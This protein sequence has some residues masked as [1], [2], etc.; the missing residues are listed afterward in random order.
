MALG[1]KAVSLGCR[2]PSLQ[3]HTHLHCGAG[4]SYRVKLET[5]AGRT[6]C[7]SAYPR[8]SSPS[9]TRPLLCCTWRLEKRILKKGVFIPNNY[10]W[11]VFQTNVSSHMTKSGLCVPE[12]NNGHQ[13]GL[14]W[15]CHRWLWFRLTGW[16][17]LRLWTE[18]T[19][20]FCPFSLVLHKMSHSQ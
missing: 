9:T 11:F 18:R 14:R 5:L 2:P 15:V 7:T 16:Y 6:G 10:P 13:W 12:S 17:L 8:N 4:N 3:L 19:S 1:W 20:H